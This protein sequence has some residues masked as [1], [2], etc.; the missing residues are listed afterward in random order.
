M[1]TLFFMIIILILVISNSLTNRPL[2]KEFCQKIKE[3][4]N[5]KGRYLRCLRF[6]DSFKMVDH[7]NEYDLDV[8]SIS[9]YTD[10][11]D[12][13]TYHMLWYWYYPD[14]KEE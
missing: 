3:R 5:L 6:D 14:V 9:S 10:E 12:M 7:V 2:Y 4:R 1:S 13:V 8:V 11:E